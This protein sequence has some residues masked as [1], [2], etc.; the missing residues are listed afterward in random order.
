MGKTTRFV[1]YK[2]QQ[3]VLNKWLDEYSGV[4][5]KVVRAYAFTPHDRDDLFQA[6]ALEL[7]NSIPKFR[8]KSKVATWMYRV[9]LYSALAW[10]RK[11]KAIQEQ[12]TPVGEFD[13]VYLHET[14]APNRRM[15]WLYERIAAL[16]TVDRSLTLLMLD[17]FS[18]RE[19]SEVTGFS[20]NNI[21]VRLTRIRKQLTELLK[22]EDCNGL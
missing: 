14:G 19:I 20:E 18:Y 9:A 13:N 12:T 16:G 10:S 15:D 21:G 22:T 6:I 7:W 1:E 3:S 11:E 8:G 4:V 5:Y 2:E 17:G